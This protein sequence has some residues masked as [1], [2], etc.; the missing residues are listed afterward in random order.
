M[1]THGFIEE[2]ELPE[3]KAKYNHAV[4][5]N[6]TLIDWKGQPVFVRFAKYAVEYLEMQIDQR[7]NPN[8]ITP[9]RKK[10]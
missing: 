6:H 7:D 3:F 5:N 4:A 9:R 8:K 2:N 10:S 1:S